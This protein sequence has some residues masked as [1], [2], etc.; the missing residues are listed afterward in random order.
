M[1]TTTLGSCFVLLSFALAGTAATAAEP[2]L[3]FPD[4]HGDTVVFAAGDDL[5]AASVAGGPA[6]RLTDH[7]GVERQPR[8]SPDGSLIAFTGELDGN[9]DV[10]VMNADG[11]DVRRLTFH[12]DDDE[13]IGW[14][15]TRGMILFRSRR[16]AM[17]NSSQESRKGFSWTE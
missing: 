8:F 9:P 4:V 11:S 16:A 2:L 17:V 12:P 15:P 5:W 7:E 1:R 3:R 14:H 13:V 10:Y 6:R